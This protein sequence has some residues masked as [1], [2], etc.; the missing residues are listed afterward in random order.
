MSERV[1]L[2]T[3]A[4]RGIGR[5]VAIELAR[6]KFSLMLVSRTEREL[7]ET[8]Q[9]AGEGSYFVGNVAKPQ[10]V[11]EAVSECVKQFGRLDTVV[12]CAGYAPILKIAEATDEQW[13][14]TIDINLSAAFYLARAAWPHFVEQKGGV[15]VNISSSATRDPFLGFTAYAAAKAGINLLGRALAKEGEPV[16]IRVHTIAP[17]STET[18]MFRAIYSKE[19]YPEKKTMDPAGVALVIAECVTGELRYTSG[20]VIWLRKTV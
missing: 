2:I 7:R 8:I 4:G 12:H 13:R 3:G 1:A 15:I 9:L 20:E 19:Q 6:R 17:G 18:K 14:D 16:G 11:N 10:A 5:A